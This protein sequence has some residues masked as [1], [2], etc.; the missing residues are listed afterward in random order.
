MPVPSLY[1]GSQLQQPL[2]HRSFDDTEQFLPTN[3]LINRSRGLPD[4]NLLKSFSADKE[5]A[6]NVAKIKVVVCL[7]DSVS[8]NASLTLYCVVNGTFAMP[9]KISQ[10]S[11]KLWIL[12]GNF[13]MKVYITGLLHRSTPYICAMFNHLLSCD[14]NPT[15]NFHCR[16]ARD[17]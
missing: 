17:H 6:N 3:K 10:G 8:L 5:K 13:K 7:F 2:H 12:C 9:T 1:D 4:N 15:D 14:N 11:C 16:C